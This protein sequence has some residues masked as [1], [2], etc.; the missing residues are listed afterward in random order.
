MSWIYAGPNGVPADKTACVIQSE[1]CKV[2]PIL[3][4]ATVFPVIY[5]F[6]F[7]NNHLS[8]TVPVGLQRSSSLRPARS[9]EEL[10]HK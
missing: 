10:T 9:V 1:Q 6:N 2:R 8:A 5:Y 4:G 3:I 7:W